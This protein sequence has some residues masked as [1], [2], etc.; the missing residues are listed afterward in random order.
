VIYTHIPYAQEECGKNIGC[1]YNKFMEILPNDDDWACF[2]DHDAMFT[3]D[4]WYKQLNDIIGREPSIGAFGCRTNRAGYKW[5]LVGNIDVDNHDIGYHRA[6]GKHLQNTHYYR[7]SPGSLLGHNREPR[8]SRF[9]GVVI[10]VK[11]STW[12]RIGGFKQTGFL[13]VD[14]DLRHRLAKHNIQFA[15]MD[16]VYVY[17][18]YRPDNPYKTSAPTLA[19]MRTLYANFCKRN[20]KFDLNGIVLPQ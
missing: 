7:T 4:D 6:I 13:A 14:D 12:K 19:A 1:A 9:S 5:Q 8:P 18:W 11:K 2:L 20:N 16:G 3:T 17:H 10:L 15:I